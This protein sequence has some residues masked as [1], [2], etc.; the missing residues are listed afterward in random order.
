MRDVY[1]VFTTRT[2]LLLEKDSPSFADWDQDD[3]AVV[4]KYWRAE[5]GDVSRD[6]AAAAAAYASVL[7]A[8]PDDAWDRAGLRSNGAEFT[9]TTL[10]Q[11]F[12]HDVTH[13]LWDV[14]A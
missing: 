2:R 9:L 7:N 12:L 13:H 11:Y 14:D 8:V 5:A 1:G 6:L 10:T 3:A 4:G